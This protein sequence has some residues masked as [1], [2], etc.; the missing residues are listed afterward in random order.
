MTNSG[1][2]VYEDQRN[3]DV[4]TVAGKAEYGLS[5][6]VALVA[7]GSYNFRDYQLRPPSVTIN[8]NSQGFEVDLGTNF[9]ISHF[10][11]GEIEV[12]YLD[13]HYVSSAFSDIT[14]L[15]A[16]GQVEWFPTQLTTLSVTVARSIGDSGLPGTPGF[17][18]SSASGEVDHELLR[19]LILIGHVDYGEQQYLA[20]ARTD[21]QWA[22]V[23]LRDGWSIAV[24]GVTLTYQYVQQVSAGAARGTN[25]EDNRLSVSTG[26]Q[27]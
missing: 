2:I 16:R 13:Q 15:A 19:N 12:G 1:A 24:L 4:T 7:T 20:I 17:L 14:G 9:D 21:D 27:W 23:S 8:S 25:Y 5:P 3:R 11:R 6:N 26:F 22:Q 10:M 18:E